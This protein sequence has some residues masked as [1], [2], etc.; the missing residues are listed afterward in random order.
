MLLMFRCKSCGFV[1]REPVALWRTVKVT[2]VEATT[3]DGTLTRPFKVCP[4]CYSDAIEVLD[5]EN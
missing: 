4:R 1:F 3:T 2:D 5:D